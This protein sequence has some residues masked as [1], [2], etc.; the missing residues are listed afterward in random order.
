ML[1]LAQPRAQKLRASA[2]FFD[3]F[4]ASPAR[5]NKKCSAAR[6]DAAAPPLPPAPPPPPPADVV[7]NLCVFL[8]GLVQQF[9]HKMDL[10]NT[11]EFQACTKIL[12][13]LNVPIK[14][15]ANFA[16]ADSDAAKTTASDRVITSSCKYRLLKNRAVA[17]LATIADLNTRSIPK[18]D[19]NYRA[20]L[21]AGYRHASDIAA[22]FL[23]DIHAESA[24]N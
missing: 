1:L 3:C 11:S 12:R 18:G 22:S 6:T 13:D 9:A 15:H 7:I 23:E 20:G 4:A 17:A 21:V 14:I 16:A 19:P 10:Q 8:H 5:S 2:N 24:I